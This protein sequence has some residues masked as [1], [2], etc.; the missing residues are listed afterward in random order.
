MYSTNTITLES[1][2]A[3]NNSA[4]SD[5]RP[6][7]TAIDTRVLSIIVW[8]QL[9]HILC[10]DDLIASRHQNIKLL[11]NRP[12]LAQPLPNKCSNDAITALETHGG[13]DGSVH[14]GQHS[15]HKSTHSHHFPIFCL[16]LHH[17]RIKSD[18]IGYDRIQLQLYPW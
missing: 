2:Y 4:R 13:T 15:T 17:T 1:Y 8:K 14:T 16:S 3:A 12:E 5:T 7:L 18:R 9:L 11:Y 10:I 6:S